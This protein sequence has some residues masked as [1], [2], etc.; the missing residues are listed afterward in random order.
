MTQVD[1]LWPN[2]DGEMA[3]RI[4]AFDWAATPL[5]PVDTWSERFK[6]MVEQMLASP[7]VSSLV[8]G[9]Q[10]ILVYNDAA[11]ALYGDHHPQALGRPLPET[12][13]DGWA[14]VATYYERAFA[15]EAVQVASQPLDTRGE[16]VAEDVFDAVLVPVR[17]ADG[18]VTSVHMTGFE[19]S[20]RLRAEAALRES[21]ERFRQF[22]ASSSDALWI[23]NAA[24]L[25]IE[26]ASPVIRTIYGVPSEAVLGDPER[27][28]ALVAPEDRDLARRH[29]ALSSRG[30]AVVH[31][32]RIRG[33]IGEEERWIRDTA[34]PLHDDSGRIQRFGGITEDVTE[35]KRTFQRLE[36]L[37]NELQHRE[38]NLIGLISA[39]AN[40]VKKQGGSIGAFDERL[41]ALRRAHGLLSQ[42]DE[43]VAVEDLVRTELAAHI[44]AASDQVTISGPDVRLTARQVQN[45]ALAL[46]ELTTNAVKYGALKV[47]TGRLLV[48]WEVV[49]DQHDQPRLELSWIETGVTINPDQLTRRGYGTELI[50]KALAYAVQAAVDY[51]LGPNG[52][53]CRIEMPIC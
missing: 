17:A 16:G 14:V 42:D 27:W 20:R 29:L 2:G 33:R 28:L 23:R 7:L 10:R 51:K 9:P 13:P 45:L 35:A 26:Y 50:Q 34:F 5:G 18:H 19:I 30:E 15:G 6:V 31:E 46:H 36:V 49:H 1:T 47:E 24:T 37:I 22:A 3:R 53:R 11:A 43:S 25:A 48:T 40:R 41:Q 39:I 52:V 38:R 8:C 44:E 32:F 4:R 21:E 12:F